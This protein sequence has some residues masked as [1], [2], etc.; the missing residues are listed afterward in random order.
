MTMNEPH[1]VTWV[2]RNSVRLAVFGVF[3]IVLGI[4]LYFAKEHV[5]RTA[6]PLKYF[7]LDFLYSLLKELGFALLIA[8]AIIEGIERVAR[9]SHNQE[10]RD[11]SRRSKKTYCVRSM[12]RTSI[13]SSSPCSSSSS[14]ENRS[15]AS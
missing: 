7:A 2:F 10:I 1:P 3:S 11:R 13:R 5:S 8:V 12:E 15:F 4:S 9:F 14:C 6:E